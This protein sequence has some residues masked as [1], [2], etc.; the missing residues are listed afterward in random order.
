MRKTKL[1]E[2]A[3]LTLEPLTPLSTK[4]HT[5]IVYMQMYDAFFHA[6]PCTVWDTKY[7]LKKKTPKKTQQQQQKEAWWTNELN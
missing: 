7:K 2:G 4:L 1:F 5:Y 6:Y 3:A